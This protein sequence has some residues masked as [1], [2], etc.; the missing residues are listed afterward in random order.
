[1]TENRRI[2]FGRVARVLAAAA[3]LAFGATELGA[4]GA[5]GKIQGT[6]IDPTGQPVANA[7]VFILGTAFAALTNET[8]FYFFNNVPA[9]TYDLRA[10]FIGYQ[11]AEVRGIRVLSD[12]TLTVNFGL[13]GAVAIEAIT[14]TAAETPIVP[15]DQVASKSI[16]TGDN[17]DQ[18]PVD[19]VA[20]VID[21][22]PGVVQ[23]T[24][25]NLSGLSIR[26]GR[27]GEA[28]VYI[29]GV[30]VRRL[31]SG[32]TQLNTGTNALEE[33]SVTTG[34][35]DA[36]FGDAQSG[37]ISLVTRTGGPRFQGTLLAE[38]DEIF[39]NTISAGF[40]RFEGS[41][42]GP[43]FGNLT[44][45]VSGLVQGNVSDRRGKG[46]ENV[47][48]YTL[49]P[50]D[51]TITIADATTGDSIA[52]DIPEFVQFTGQC[53]AASNLGF[54][55]QGRRRPYDFQ[56]NWRANAKLTYTY[57]QGSRVS[58]SGLWDQDQNRLTP[59]AMMYN[60]QAYGG[61]RANSQV[62]ILNWVQQVFRTAET[63][64]AFDLNLSYQ[65]DKFRQGALTREWEMDHRSPNMGIDFSPMQFVVDFDN[66]SPDDNGDRSVTQLKSQDDWDRLMKNVQ[67]N[68]GTRMP[69]LGRDDLRYN[70]A[71][72]MNPYALTTGFSTGGLNDAGGNAWFLNDERRILGRLN[73]DWQFDRYNRLKFGVEGLSGQLQEHSAGSYNRQIFQDAYSDSPTRWAAYIQDRLDLGDVVLELGLRWDQYNINGFFPLTPSRIF[74]HPAYDP[75]LTAEDMACSGA[76]CDAPDAIDNFVWQTSK[77]HTAWS[78]RLRVSFP[79]TDRTNFRLSYAHQVQSPPF[80]N[81]LQA[82]NNDITITNTNDS[83]GGDVRHGKSILFEFGIRHAFTRDLVFDI[84]AFNKDKVADLAYRLVDFFDPLNQRITPVNVLTNADFGNIKGFDVSLLFRAGNWF[85]GQAA[86]TF[87]SAKG[88]GSNPF[89]Y[90]TTNARQVS[91]V[92]GERLD[93][94]QAITRTDD[95]RT[96]NIVGSMAFNWPGD[97]QRGSWYGE[98]LRNG[99]LFFRWRIISGLPY[100]RL[101]NTGNGQEAFGGTAFGLI[102]ERQDD[103]LNA[104]ELP[105]QYWF[106]LRVTKGFRLGPTDWT[107]YADFRNLFNVTNVLGVFAETGDVVNEQ[108]FETAIT[109]ELSRLRTDAGAGRTTVDAAN[110]L[111]AFDVRDCFSG[112]A[113]GG[114]GGPADCVLVQ[115]AE[116]RFGDGNGLYDLDEYEAAM[117]VWYNRFDG[118]QTFNGTP[119]HIRLGVELAF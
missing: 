21:L 91:Q 28:V 34:A 72:R 32:Q 79:V 3:L 19:D 36:E 58:V 29:D 114:S 109:A 82:K 24:Q 42:S 63:E 41:L 64:L 69:Y 22:Q 110:G 59:G 66:Y 15:R 77:S 44:F 23:G 113:W 100:T 76:E 14:I 61:N 92:T 57:G 115:K 119:L 18:L 70:Q 106:D 83:F 49:G 13:S 50:L 11:P 25:G 111:E 94:P 39:G 86:Y 47:P 108:D 7:Q 38:T 87:Q 84:S 2:A 51:T 20:N 62:F 30:P 71:Y 107:L 74:T 46:W 116:A 112:S 118:V 67:D 10:Q 4:Q 53:D 81:V 9:G 37:V 31:G 98:L 78:P 17:I 85:N 33:A 73:V 68:L 60:P 102:S 40:N 1:M 54:E 45:F 65:T 99:G 103:V 43:I 26:G 93:P 52:L 35:M 90:L 12:Q 8:G 48:E 97:F 5:T 16:A 105:W 104:S 27:P 6:V 80:D 88:T 95:D 101:V 55:C 117:T 89:S 96:H 56:T 75:D